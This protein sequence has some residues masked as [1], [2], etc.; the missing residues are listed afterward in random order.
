M[1]YKK[2]FIFYFILLFIAGIRDI[3][4]K[5]IKNWIPIAI[6]ISAI[7][8]RLLGFVEKQSIFENGNGWIGLLLG[9]APFFFTA[10][11]LGTEKMGGGDV[12]FMAA[13]GVFLGERILAASMIGMGLATIFLFF[14]I[15]I[16]REKKGI[17]LAPFLGIG[18]ICSLLIKG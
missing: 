9:A 18:C 11:F 7:L 1:I 15:L 6:V 13:N 3:Q 16:K 10:F 17:A 5:Q 2:I 14:C 4:T 8:Y 12:K